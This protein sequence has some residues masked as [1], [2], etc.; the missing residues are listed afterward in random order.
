MD[1][2]AI[3]LAHLERLLERNKI[4]FLE[5]RNEKGDLIGIFKAT[6]KDLMGHLL[7]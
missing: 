3:N 6:T 1:Y 5:K 4:V 2:N 7:N